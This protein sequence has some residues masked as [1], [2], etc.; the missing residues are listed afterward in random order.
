MKENINVFVRHLNIND[1]RRLSNYCLTQFVPGVSIF[2]GNNHYYP[3]G[4][5]F[6]HQLQARFQQNYRFNIVSPE[7]KGSN[8]NGG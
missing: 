2:T 1:F 7:P 4:S 8:G 5:V 6:A 3:A